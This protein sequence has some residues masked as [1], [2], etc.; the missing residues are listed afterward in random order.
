[1]QW[2]LTRAQA[3]RLFGQNGAVELDAKI[4]DGFGGVLENWSSRDD[5]ESGEA[6][7]V[8]D[9]TNEDTRPFLLDGYGRNYED[10]LDSA[11]IVFVPRQLALA[12]S[13]GNEVA[14]K[15]LVDEIRAH[16]GSIGQISI[17]PNWSKSIRVCDCDPPSF[18]IET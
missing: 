16:G 10:R 6:T 11:G 7:L 14:L 1:M 9:R 2:R 4:R 15:Q 8:M 3:E 5:P 13:G 17:G 18:Y 12:A